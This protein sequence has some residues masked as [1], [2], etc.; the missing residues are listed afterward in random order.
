M[1]VKWEV[2][3]HKA[4]YKVYLFHF[5]WKTASALYLGFP[6]GCWHR[7]SASLGLGSA[8]GR[9]GL[10]NLSLESADQRVKRVQGEAW[11]LLTKSEQCLRVTVVPGEAQ[12]RTTFEQ[13]ST[14]VWDSWS[15]PLGSSK[16]KRNQTW[17]PNPQLQC[18]Q[19]SHLRCSFLFP[20]RRLQWSERFCFLAEWRNQVANHFLHILQRICGLKLQKAATT[21]F[22]GKQ[23]T[24]NHH[25][26]TINQQELH[27]TMCVML[28]LSL[29]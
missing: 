19:V 7:T 20:S 12:H 8:P 21:A 2:H 26:S 5:L 13:F 11:V 14:K 25:W 23:S 16:S 1:K 18:Q 3:Q 4:L 15:C 17:H 28:C 10:Q 27:K 29:L 22:W 9:V 24:G 6:M